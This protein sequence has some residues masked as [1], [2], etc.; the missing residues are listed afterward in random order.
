MQNRTP[1]PDFGTSSTVDE[2]ELLD[3]SIIPRFHLD[4]I[5]SRRV[6]RV[7]GFVGM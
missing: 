2:F 5:V 7:A 1:P 6:A 3:D 4:S